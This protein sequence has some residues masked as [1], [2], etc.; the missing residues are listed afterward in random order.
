MSLIGTLKDLSLF[1]LVQLHCCERQQAQVS[2]AHGG[3]DGRLVFAD[4]ELVFAAVGGLV[5]GEAVH[6][7]L[8][9][10][11]GDFRVDYE[12]APVVRNVRTPWSELL[13]EGVRR[14]DEA[15][16]ARDARLEATL[17]SM[18]G[19]HGL[20]ATVATNTTGQVR[21]AATAGPAMAEAA[22]VAF[23][24]GRLETIGGLLHCGACRE[25]SVS[26]PD[27]T[28]WIARRDGAY[29][30]CWLDGRAALHPVK[31]LLQPLLSWERTD[32]PQVAPDA[33]SFSR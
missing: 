13:L 14:L 7:L 3:C 17:R 24:A 18:K 22:L 9:W 15:R 16:A 20:R 30:A 21:A 29:L 5:G 33:S 25:V 12:P 26:G 31:R 8:T 6:E 28:I 27:E 10:E 23:L 19:T 32:A 2:L 4:G 11:D 1:N